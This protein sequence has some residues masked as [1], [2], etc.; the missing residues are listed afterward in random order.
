MPEIVG[1]GLIGAG[2]IG[3]VHAEQYLR[4]PL[5]HALP[6]VDVK[7]RAVADVVPELRKSAA[8]EYGFERQYEDWHEL[9]ADPEVTLVDICVPNH[10]HREIAVAAAEAGKHIYCEKPMSMSGAEG[11]AMYEAAESAG[12]LHAVNFNY[13]KAPAVTFARE[14]LEQGLLGE[15]YHFTAGISLDTGAN[16]N[17]PWSWRFDSSTAGGGS[18]FTMGSHVFDCARYLVG[19]V[20]QVVST[21]DTFVTERPKNGGSGKV[22]V[23]DSASVIA[24]FENGATGMLHTTWMAHGRKHYFHWEINA[25]RGSL[26]FNSERLNEIQVFEADQPAGRQGFKTVYL[27]E[28]HPYGQVMRRKAGR[29][30]GSQETFL[31]QVYDL[32]KAIRDG[33]PASPSFYDG[34]QVDRV[35]QAVTESSDTGSWVKL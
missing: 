25:S 14:L 4:L 18:L 15:V 26:A 17:A 28:E 35:L 9:L 7:L 3:R 20:A 1:V 5:L 27:G 32:L 33:V 13:R 29:G 19:E 34:W 23:D 22:S 6:D 11:Q 30:M 10:L 2:W 24:R 8:E 21:L 12:V 31:I 16:P